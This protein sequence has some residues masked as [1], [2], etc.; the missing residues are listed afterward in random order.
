MSKRTTSPDPD[1]KPLFRAFTRQSLCELKARIEQIKARRQETDAQ[2][3]LI[4]ETENLAP[5][6]Q[7]EANKAL[8]IPLKRQFPKVLTA[9]PIE[10]IDSYYT[11]MGISTFVVIS[12][13]SD[14]WRFNSANAMYLLS[15]FHPLRR[16]A[17]YM[18]THP[19]FSFFV[20]ATILTN[21]VIMTLPSS[22]SIENTEIIF[23]TI[24]SFESCL[25]VTA[26]GFIFAKFTYLRDPWNWLDF[27]V[28]VVAYITMFAESFGNLSALRTFRVLRALKTV[29]I[30][31]GMK[32]IVGAVIESVKN[33][34][35]VIILT[36]FSLSIFALLGLQIY[37]G[38]L[39]QTC[40]LNGPDNMTD[41]EWHAWN[42]NTSH[43]VKHDIEMFNLC[44]NQSEAHI[45][46]K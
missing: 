8:P 18:L 46:N 5:N 21:C 2:K 35:D 39:T 16:V 14:I 28:I 6:P 13:N 37:V 42:S 17:I 24:Y 7:L 1:E 36:C 31:P 15:P 33:L 23:T 12:K 38:V 4:E 45:L 34:K 29:A 41:D 30:I 26:R 44:S 32:T 27:L 25:K 3:E 43:H 10:E 11:E 22:K 19:Y 40:I 9:T 20:I